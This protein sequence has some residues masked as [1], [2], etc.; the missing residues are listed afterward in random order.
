MPA[1]CSRAF[2]TSSSLR[3]PCSMDRATV[4]MSTTLSRPG[5]EGIPIV[6]RMSRIVVTARSSMRRF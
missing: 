3:H 2:R 5:P 1:A 6:S 4:W